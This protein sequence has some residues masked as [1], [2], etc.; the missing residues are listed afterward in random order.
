MLGPW[1]DRYHMTDGQGCVEVRLRAVDAALHWR[2]TRV[3][4]AFVMPP[5]MGRERW[6][7][8]RAAGDDGAGPL[9][10]GGV[11]PRRPFVPLMRWR[12]A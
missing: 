12:E 9:S 10:S 4:F 5:S 6:R 1:W 8:P 11:A 2:N 7:C 3:D